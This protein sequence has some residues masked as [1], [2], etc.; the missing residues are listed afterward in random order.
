[1]DH[2]LIK[3]ATN[4]NVFYLSVRSADLS[5]LLLVNLIAS[6][7]SMNITLF[8]LLHSSVNQISTLADFEECEQL[9]ELYLRKN[10]IQDLS[11]LAYIQVSNVFVSANQ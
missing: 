8:L 5:L 11:E 9:Q 4:G 1:M 7:V 3:Y 2:F 6:T 10:N